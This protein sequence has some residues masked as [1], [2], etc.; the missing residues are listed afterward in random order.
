MK[1][2][3]SCLVAI[4]FVLAQSPEEL[5]EQMTIEEKYSILKGIGWPA[6]DPALGYY[7]GNIP[8]ISRLGIPSLNMHDGPQGFRTYER[9]QIDQVTSWP[10]SLAVAAT[11]NYKRVEEWA[12]AMAREFRSKVRKP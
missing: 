10:C 9:P 2:I 12:E 7:V 11:W 8:P 6:F 3:W 4:V 5:L 1:S